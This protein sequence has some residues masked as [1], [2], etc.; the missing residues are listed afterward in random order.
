M[1]Y[2]VEPIVEKNGYIFLKLT[3]ISHQQINVLIME[4]Q[5]RT[6]TFTKNILL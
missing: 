6:S 1:L 2:E 4:E 3:N 5:K